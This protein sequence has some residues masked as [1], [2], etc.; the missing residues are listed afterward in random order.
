MICFRDPSSNVQNPRS[1][2][3]DTADVIS[4][5]FTKF[6]N[7]FKVR[8]RKKNSWLAPLNKNFK[9]LMTIFFWKETEPWQCKQT[10]RQI[11]DW[12]LDLPFNF[13]LRTLFLSRII[14]LGTFQGSNNIKKLKWFSFLFFFKLLEDATHVER[15]DTFLSHQCNFIQ[16]EILRSRGYQV[17][18]VVHWLNKYAYEL[19]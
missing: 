6:Q 4:R 18:S 17:K 12:H 10:N 7:F 1:F 15:Y 5:I 2:K 3:L 14:I 9:V 16:S 19:R 8:K 13:R 11:S